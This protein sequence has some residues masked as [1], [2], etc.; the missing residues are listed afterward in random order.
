MKLL[1]TLE[2]AR[3]LKVTVARVQQLIWSGRLPARKL[4]RDYVIAQEDLKLVRHRKAGRP[5]KPTGKP[6][7]P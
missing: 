1:T 3:K 4:G 5:S 6:K 7:L 2:A